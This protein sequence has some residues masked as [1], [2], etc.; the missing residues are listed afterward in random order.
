MKRTLAAA[1]CAAATLLATLVTGCSGSSSSP[2]SSSSA[3]TAAAGAHRATAASAAAAA[4]AKPAR[5]TVSTR[6]AGHL[7]V[8]LV[9]GKGNTLYLFEADKKD[10]STCTGR[11][12]VAWPPLLTTGNARVGKGTDPKLLGTTRRAGG[13][14]QVTY[15][16]HPLYTYVGDTRPGQTNGQGLNQFGA[17]WYVLDTKGKQVTT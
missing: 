2:S 8:I 6:A 17:L 3:S 1:S 16:G 10:K 14:E 4:T 13:V 7:G 15:K 9:D 11:C 5:A 12:A